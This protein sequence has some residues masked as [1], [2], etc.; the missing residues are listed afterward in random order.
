MFVN[1][2]NKQGRASEISSSSFKHQQMTKRKTTGD[3]EYYPNPSISSLTDGVIGAEITEAKDNHNHNHEH[4]HQPRPH[5]LLQYSFV[6]PKLISAYLDARDAL[7][8]GRCCKTIHHAIGLRVLR[9]FHLWSE[10]R[11]LFK[12]ERNHHWDH[13]RGDEGDAPR[14]WQPITIPIQ[15]LCNTQS[16][17]HS[18]SHSTHTHTH[19][20]PH[21][22][23]HAHLEASSS[24][25]LVKNFHSLHFTCTWR[26]RG[27]GQRKGKLL[28]VRHRADQ[29][30]DKHPPVWSSTSTSDIN[31]VNNSTSTA[32]VAASE[33]P[34]QSP[35][36]VNST[37]VGAGGADA[38]TDTDTSIATMIPTRDASSSHSNNSNKKDDNCANDT[39]GVVILETPPG[40]DAPVNFTTIE[41]EVTLDPLSSIEYQYS[42]WVFV[43][44]GG[45]HGLTI[46]D[47]ALTCALV[48]V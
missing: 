6:L 13:W 5:L 38:H 10:G 47:L 48:Y 45:G 17:T 25:D 30:C 11:L 27:W 34:R 16:S 23:P 2:D 40:P 4:E 7:S 28:V 24:S 3:D 8:L 31:N 43:G 39:G 9:N 46:S 14:L 29:D 41:F 12:L 20:R 26:D 37:S 1:G 36:M 42:L 44:N 15:M 21:P 35:S 18:T 19:P 32:N 22:H 33:S